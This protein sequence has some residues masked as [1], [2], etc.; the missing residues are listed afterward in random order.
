M[1]IEQ[2][3]ANIIEAIDFLSPKALEDLKS[4]VN[5]LQFKEQP[6]YSETAGKIVKL[7]GLWKDLPFDINDEDIRQARREL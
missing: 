5:F 7:E 6:E 4:F 2:T 1:N 3:K